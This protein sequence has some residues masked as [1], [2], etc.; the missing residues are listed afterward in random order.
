MLTSLALLPVFWI[1]VHIIAFLFAMYT[2]RQLNN[3]FRTA[4]MIMKRVSPL[5][6]LHNKWIMDFILNRSGAGVNRPMPISQSVFHSPK[7]II[8]CTR[9]SGVT[10]IVNHTAR[11]TFFC[12]SEQQLGQ[13]IRI[14][15]STENSD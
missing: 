4:L 5:D 14:I 12:T 8:I 11:K 1:L 10:Q 6:L 2:Q 13:S 3:L 7:D 15:F 9:L